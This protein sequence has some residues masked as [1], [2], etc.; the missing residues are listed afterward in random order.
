MASVWKMGITLHVLHKILGY[1]HCAVRGITELPKWLCRFIQWGNS[2]FSTSLH[3]S[4]QKIPMKNIANNWGTS[5]PQGPVL[6]RITEWLS[7]RSG[8]LVSP[9]SWV[10]LKCVL[11]D[12]NYLGGCVKLKCASAS[13]QKPICTSDQ[14]QFL[15]VYSQA[16]AANT[17]EFH[18]KFQIRRK[19][20]NDT[21][22]IEKRR[23]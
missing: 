21:W 22:Q 3:P 12:E 20:I 15:S 2:V 23:K 5:I 14:S 19:E 8:P 6:S 16:C 9:C 11:E 13:G 10:F 17:P 18:G 1:S 4:S 7:T